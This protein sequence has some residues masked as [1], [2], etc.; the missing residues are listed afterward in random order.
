MIIDA[1]VA[2]LD[3]SQGSHEYG[4]TA[5]CAGSIAIDV[6]LFLAAA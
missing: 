2:R 6:H 4:A 5:Y 1:T 3:A